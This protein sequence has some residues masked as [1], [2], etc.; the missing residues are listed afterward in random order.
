M[1]IHLD[2]VKTA[3]RLTYHNEHSEAGLTAL[4][5]IIIPCYTWSLQRRYLADKTQI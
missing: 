5:F 4:Y 1:D 3:I 2:A